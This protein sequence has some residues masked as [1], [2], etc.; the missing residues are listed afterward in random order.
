[1]PGR[2]E[3]LLEPDLRRRRKVHAEAPDK[4]QITASKAV[5]RLVI[6]ADH[7]ELIVIRREQPK[8]TI[9]C[10]AHILIFVG[11]HA[12]EPLGPSLP[13]DL[14]APAWPASARAAGLRNRPRCRRANGADTRHR[15]GQLRARPGASTASPDR[16]RG[17][18]H[19]F[20]TC[21][22][23]LRRDQAVLELRDA[24]AHHL[25]RIAAVRAIA[26]AGE[27]H[28]LH[29]APDE[30][31]AIVARRGFRTPGGDPRP[32]ARPEAGGRQGHERFQPSLAARCR[33]DAT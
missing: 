27:T 21:R 24:V 5:D 26:A 31:A 15:P 32:R 6:V 19:A 28:R 17:S 13:I 11:E 20:N 18:D 1:M 7:E 8:P 2:A 4:S 29:R 23:F 14:A 16:P 3:I 12:V 9:L 30:A 10:V 22:G 33:P 25:Q